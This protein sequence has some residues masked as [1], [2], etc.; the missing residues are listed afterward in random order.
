[1]AYNMCHDNDICILLDG[2]DWLY[3]E[4]ALVY[5]NLFMSYNKVD[6]TYRNFVYYTNNVCTWILT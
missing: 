5:L 3:S 6:I 1:M 4:Y 2:D